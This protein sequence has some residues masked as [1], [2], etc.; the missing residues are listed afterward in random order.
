MTAQTW[1]APQTG[2]GPAITVRPVRTRHARI[3]AL[4]AKLLD[5]ADARWLAALAAALELSQRP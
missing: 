3:L 4:E 5:Q 2:G 1:A